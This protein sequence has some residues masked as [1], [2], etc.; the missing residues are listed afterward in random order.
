MTGE[1]DD[2]GEELFVTALERADLRAVDGR[3]VLAAPGLRFVDQRALTRLREYAR[4]RD[5]A[6][7]LRTPHPAAARLAALLDLPGLTAEVTR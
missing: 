4:R 6:V 7:L 3:L 5:S 1:L 2:A